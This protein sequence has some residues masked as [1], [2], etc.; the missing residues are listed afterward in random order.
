MA[1]E[2]AAPPRVH[3]RSQANRIALA[4][5]A[6]LVTLVVLLALDAGAIGRYATIARTDSREQAARHENASLLW[7]AEHN[8]GA[9]GVAVG[10][11]LVGAAI[12]RRSWPLAVLGAAAIAADQ[13]L[14]LARRLADALSSE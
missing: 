13:K 12:F 7:A 14:P 5:G 9:A 3:A 2:S 6:G 1:V 11:V 8:Y 10:V 4:V